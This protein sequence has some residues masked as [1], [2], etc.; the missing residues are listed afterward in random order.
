MTLA[1]A[2]PGVALRPEPSPVA[3]V[4]AVVLAR[5]PGGH[6]AA[7]VEAVVAQT[8]RPDALLVID[9]TPDASAGHDVVD[10]GP[11]EFTAVVAVRA[12]TGVLPHRVVTETLLSGREEA[13]TELVN[14]H[15]HLWLLAGAEPERDA[16]ARQL[17]ALR[18]SSSAGAAGPKLLLPGEGSRLR[19]MGY[20]LTRSGRLVAAPPVGETDQGQYDAR[21][22]TLAVPLEG[23]LVERDLFQRLRGFDAGLGGTGS[24]VDFG[25]RAQQAGRRVVLVPRARVRAGADPTPWPVRRREVRRAALTRCSLLVA[26]FLAAWITFSALG[27]AIGLTLVKRPRAAWRELGD[28]GAVV[29]PFRV[30]ASRWRGRGTREVSRRHLSSL[31]LGARGA[32][33]YADEA[34]DASSTAVVPGD[35]SADVGEAPG[36]PGPEPD[37]TP[38]SASLPPAPAVLPSLET[39]PTAAEEHGLDTLPEP[40]LGRVLSNPGVV[41][42]VAA[43]AMTVVA[44]RS[45]GGSLAERLDGGVVGGDIVGVRATSA[46]LWHAWLDT[47]KGSGLGHTGEASPSLVV[48]AAMAWLREHVP[49]TDPASS[50]GGSAA[51]VL[52]AAAI[53]LGAATAY[54]AGRAVTRRPWLRALAALGWATT[55]VASTAIAGGRL[56]PAVAVVLLPL[57]A[58]GFARSA[59]RGGTATATFAT[60]LGASVLGAFVPPLLALFAASALVLF[61]LGRGGQRMRALVLLVL[62]PA[63]QGPWV[64]ELWHD[65]RQ[66]L[67]GGPGLLSWG[68][69]VPPAWQVALL[70]PGGPGSYPVLFSAPL[71]ALAVAAFARGGRRGPALSSLAVLA[72]VS[73]AAALAAPRVVLGTVPSSLPHDGAPITPWTGVALLPYG[74]AVLAAG[75]VGASGLSYSFGQVRWRAVSRW[76][77]VLGATAAVLASAGWVAWQTFGDTLSA[78]RDPRPAVAVDQADGGLANRMLFLEPAPSASDAAAG[79]PTGYRL[80]GREV[81]GLTRVLP[82]TPGDLSRDERL[83]ATVR[84]LLGGL[85]PDAVGGQGSGTGASAS[86][87]ASVLTRAAVGFVGL[88]ADET[89]P[90]I[91]AL[92]ATAGLARSGTRDGVLVWRVLPQAGSSAAGPARLALTTGAAVHAVPATGMHAAT[93]VLATTG[94]GARLVVAESRAWAGHARVAVDGVVLS[95]LQG[96]TTPEYAVPG[97]SGLLTVDVPTDFARWRLAQGLLLA[98]VLFLALPFGT[99]TAARG[100][101]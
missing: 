40:W 92:D 54:L 47:W 85:A 70:H 35:L 83:D 55:A 43:A 20:Q 96:T 14:R 60:A 10:P 42:T 49:F 27:S 38:K 90:R 18:V 61:L 87:P 26:P 36:H 3:R 12:A 95:P 8:R 77:L 48:L 50:P 63:L 37:S 98:L 53:P 86:S 29:N 94:S 7:V 23:M 15:D 79:S 1:P 17:D 74:L 34:P 75:L 91:R 84:G 57:V 39:G 46:S 88:Q 97:G 78:W 24:E 32:L 89:D 67:A 6:V 58:A 65:P 5:E 76:P 82:S 16:L 100:K 81:S 33:R 28:V 72:T 80:V 4:M 66:L 21:I 69:P 45:L 11:E 41:V 99:G 73:L 51:A 44:G 13:V 64:L 59:R 31:F 9:A 19:S 71:L 2:R 93:R 52:L 22:D 30:L 62:P 68:D 56:G 101:P 25:W